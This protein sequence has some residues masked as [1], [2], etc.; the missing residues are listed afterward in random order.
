MPIIDTHQYNPDTV[1]L[2]V[3]TTVLRITY[4]PVT[5]DPS[6]YNLIQQTFCYDIG[7][8]G[9]PMSGELKSNKRKI[10]VGLM[11][12]FKMLVKKK[13]TDCDGFAVCLFLFFFLAFDFN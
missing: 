11:S 2:T 8:K 13:R 10:R 9:G 1:H 3:L 12:R 7:H 5:F 6:R 4:D